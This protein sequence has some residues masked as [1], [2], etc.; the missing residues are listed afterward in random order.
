[1]WKYVICFGLPSIKNLNTSLCRTISTAFKSNKND[2]KIALVFISGGEGSR[3]PVQYKFH[4]NFYIVSLLLLILQTKLFVFPNVRAITLIDLLSSGRTT[5]SDYRSQ[6][7]WVKRFIQP[8]SPKR[9]VLIQKYRQLKCD[10]FLNWPLDQPVD[11]IYTS[12]YLSKPLRPLILF[13]LLVLDRK[14]LCS[15]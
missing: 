2:N 15:V 5:L 1:M 10:L 9:R 7:N 8:L 12:I 14:I 13:F 6:Y 4:I 3:T 11:A